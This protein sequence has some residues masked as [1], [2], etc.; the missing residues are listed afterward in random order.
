MVK[1]SEPLV[2]EKHGRLSLAATQVHFK[3]PCNFHV[4]ILRML[5]LGT[6][7]SCK[8]LKHYYRRRKAPGRK[9][10]ELRAIL[11]VLTPMETTWNR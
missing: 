2:L 7:P 8:K 3:R 1:E 4:H 5:A 10:L 6:Q 9:I 11:G